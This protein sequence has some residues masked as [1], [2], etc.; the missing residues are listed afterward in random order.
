MRNRDAQKHTDPT[1]PDP[2]ADPDADPE[3]LVKSHEV[4][5]K[6]KKSRF[7]FSLQ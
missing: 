6:Q 1:D 5:T 4:V 2:D 7:F 3:L